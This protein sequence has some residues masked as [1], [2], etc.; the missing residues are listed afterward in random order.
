LAD[1]PARQG[2][3]NPWSVHPAAR[4]LAE[5]IHRFRRR[6]SWLLGILLIEIIAL[7][8][9]AV[10]LAIVDQGS[11]FYPLLSGIVLVIWMF[12][13]WKSLRL[14]RPLLTTELEDT[15]LRLEPDRGEI[16]RFAEARR[17]KL[18]KHAAP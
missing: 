1:K 2:I 9:V 12:L 10:A 4:Y 15:M 17:Q 18:I 14:E 8:V 7:T 11:F 6:Y 13:V 16:A 5:E 3:N